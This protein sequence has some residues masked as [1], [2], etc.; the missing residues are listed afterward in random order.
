MKVHW[1]T[2][3]KI[4]GAKLSIIEYFEQILVTCTSE[5]YGLACLA[6]SHAAQLIW[7]KE[8]KVRF[9]RFKP[10]AAPGATNI[11]QNRCA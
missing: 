3:Y 8:D 7:R 11:I 5:K 4:Y 10:H 2:T 6:D 1:V 9:R